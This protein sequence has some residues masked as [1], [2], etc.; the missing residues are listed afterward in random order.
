M[1]G[2]RRRPVIALVTDA[3]FPYHRGGKEVRYHELA[4]RLALVADV[5]VYTMR[6]WGGDRAPSERGVSYRAL[7][8][9]LPLYAHGRRSIPQAVVFALACLR[10]LPRRFDA[11]EADHMPYM[12][13]FVLR[14]V[15]SLRRRPLVVTW[16][17]VWGAAYWRAYLGR[18]GRVGWWL[19]RAAMKLPDR[20]IAASPQTAERLAGRLRAGVQVTIAPNGVDLERARRATA[21]PGSVSDLVVVSRLL[22]HKRIDL[23]I[24]AVALLREQG[25]ALTCRVIGEGPERAALH[26]QAHALG[27]ADLVEFRHDVESHDELYSLL[28]AARLFAFPSEREGFGIALL[29]ALAC[30]LP[31]LT[32]SAPDNLARHIAQRSPRGTVCAPDAAAFAAAALAAVR[33]AR[34]PTGPAVGADVEDL[35]WLREYDWDLVAERVA[36]T[37]LA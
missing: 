28:K 32:T 21:A 25:H 4:P 19:E 10:L 18:A 16:H 2:A 6:W 8:P 9:L 14:L 34:A 24:D 30:G 26:A 33:G 36:R 23:L 29:E 37:V 7:C 31:V 22:A 17:E 12:Q 13:L 3:I 11:L 20:V 5:H 15:A 1:S 35:G 27:V